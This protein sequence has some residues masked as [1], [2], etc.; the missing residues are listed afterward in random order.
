MRYVAGVMIVLAMASCIVRR[1][2]GPKVTGTCAG[3]CDHYVECKAGHL[4]ADHARC[5]RECPDV[6]GDRDALAEF[7]RLSCKDAV[8]YVDGMPRAAASQP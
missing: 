8:E 7:E 6:F 5:T 1:L 3:A 4:E 2:S